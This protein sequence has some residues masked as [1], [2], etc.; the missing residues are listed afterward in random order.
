MQVSEDR[1]T[2]WREQKIA[3]GLLSAVHT[4][5]KVEFNTVDLV[6]SRLLL[7]SAKNRQQSRLLPYTFNFV[8]GFGNKLATTSIRHLVVVDF[9]ANKFNFVAGFGNNLNSPSCHGRLCCRY[10]QLCCP[11]VERPFDFVANV[12]RAEATWSTLSTFNKVNRVELYRLT[13]LPI[14]STLL[15]ELGFRFQ[16]YTDC[17]QICRTDDH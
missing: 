12:Y 6:E 7:K 2:L 17:A 10:I 5:N 9:V 15:P 1:P 8:A 14:W 16:Q 3:D 13:F 4:G 11:N